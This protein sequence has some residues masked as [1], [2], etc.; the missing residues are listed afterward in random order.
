MW[1]SPVAP[2]WAGKGSGRMMGKERPPAVLPVPFLPS[3]RCQLMETKASLTVHR[4]LTGSFIPSVLGRAEF[5][6]GHLGLNI[7][8]KRRR[9][10]VEES[11][12]QPCHDV[13]WEPCAGTGGS[14]KAASRKGTCA[15]AWTGMRTGQGQV[16]GEAG[17]VPG[18]E[19]AA[20]AKAYRLEN[21]AHY[22]S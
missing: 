15:E 7:E 13:E 14:G 16:K 22:K 1:D 2:C 20:C 8:L 6:A 5:C 21:S 4:S 11:H 12:Q 9:D 10:L 17:S 18:V 19:G 3:P